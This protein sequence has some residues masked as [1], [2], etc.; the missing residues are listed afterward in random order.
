M[1]KLMD[2][3]MFIILHS[4]LCLCSPLLYISYTVSY[5][6]YTAHIVEVRNLL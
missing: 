1:Y 3:K 4:E 2:K 6:L 5:M